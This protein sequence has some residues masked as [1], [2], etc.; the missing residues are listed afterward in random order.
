[1]IYIRQLSVDDGI[2]VYNMLQKIPDGEN[3]FVNDANGLSFEEYK[4]WLQESDEYSRQVGI[5][6]GWRVPQTI[7]WLIYDEKPIGFGKLRHF[8]T[9]KLLEHGGNIGYAIIPSERSKGYSKIFVNE[10]LKEAKKLSIEKVLFTADKDN[11]AS[12]KAAL[13]CGGVLE[14]TDEHSVYIWVNCLIP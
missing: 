7:Y 13:T 12:I 9:E 8:M 5:K 10:L 6:D 1:M 14:R 11:T 3:G 4:N 2:D